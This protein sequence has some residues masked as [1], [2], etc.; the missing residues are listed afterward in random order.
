[1][2]YLIHREGVLKK[3][4]AQSAAAIT[5]QRYSTVSHDEVIDFHIFMEGFLVFHGSFLCSEGG[6]VS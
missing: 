2:L 1:M 4:M 3:T 6:V 5:T